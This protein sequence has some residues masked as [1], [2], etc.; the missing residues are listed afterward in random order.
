MLATCSRYFS[1]GELLRLLEL[2]AQDHQVELRAQFWC[3]IRCNP[4]QALA[5]IVEIG[6]ESAL[7]QSTKKDEK[8]NGGL[9][10]RNGEG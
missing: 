2:S 10:R 3:L 8:E 5:S 7:R 4:L 1:V 9:W 6:K